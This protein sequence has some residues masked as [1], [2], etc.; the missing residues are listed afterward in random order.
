MINSFKMT[1]GKRVFR[2]ALIC[3]TVPTLLNIVFGVILKHIPNA[4]LR[5]FIEGFV[6]AS[7]GLT[8]VFMAMLLVL[9]I[10]N[11]NNAAMPGYRFF[12]SVSGGAERFKKSLIF[13]N[14]ISL[15][16]AALYTVSWLFVPHND[17]I[18][19]IAATVLFGLGWV[20]I[21]GSR[22]KTILNF[23][24]FFIVGMFLSLIALLMI[25]AAVSVILYIVSAVYVFVNAKKLWEK[26][27]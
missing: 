20:N 18:I 12:H 21:I 13:A 14:M 17:F 3:L 26:E 25:I 7:G 15:I 2:S 22:G 27:M 24:P 9:T 1:V 10:Y 19:L 5:D 6:S 8:L 4:H 11:S 23:I 16:A